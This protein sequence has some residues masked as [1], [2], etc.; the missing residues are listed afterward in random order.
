MNEIE[1]VERMLGVLDPAIHMHTAFGA[2]VPLNGGIGI[3]DLQLRGILA[4]ADLVARHNGDLREHCPC[5][6]PA[7]GA[8]AHVIVGAL[9]ANAHNDRIARALA[10]ER[11]TRKA[12]R[13]W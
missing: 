3:H 6:L 5:R 7:F 13:S 2:G 9:S 8:S 11:P 1:P 10:L 4:D 12:R